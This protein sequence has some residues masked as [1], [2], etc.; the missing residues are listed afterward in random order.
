MSPDLHSKAQEI[1]AALKLVSEWIKPHEKDIQRLKLL[2]LVSEWVDKILRLDT[3]VKDLWNIMKSEQEGAGT[4]WTKQK[5]IDILQEFNQEEEIL[6]NALGIPEYTSHG[7]LG[8]YI[9]SLPKKRRLG[10]IAIM[11]PFFQRIKLI[12][13]AIK[14][15]ITNKILINNEWEWSINGLDQAYIL[16]ALEHFYEIISGNSSSTE[17]NIRI[18]NFTELARIEYNK[19]HWETNP[20]LAFA[21]LAYAL[22][23]HEE[24]S[25]KIKKWQHGSSTKL[26]ITLKED[27]DRCDIKFDKNTPIPGTVLEIN[28]WNNEH[29]VQN[30]ATALDNRYHKTV[31]KKA[32]LLIESVPMIS[33]WST[34]TFRRYPGIRAIEFKWEDIPIE[35]NLAMWLSNS[36]S[37]NLHLKKFISALLELKS[38][39]IHGTE[40]PAHILEILELRNK[41]I[42]SD[43]WEIENMYSLVILYVIENAQTFSKDLLL[44]IFEVCRK[45]GIR[46]FSPEIWNIIFSRVPQDPRIRTLHETLKTSYNPSPYNTEFPSKSGELLTIPSIF[47]LQDLSHFWLDSEVKKIFAHLEQNSSVV[48]ADLSGYSQGWKRGEYEWYS[49]RL[50]SAITLAMMHGDVPESLKNFSLVSLDIEK[51]KWFM[52]MLFAFLGW[53]EGRE[54]GAKMDA[55]QSIFMN[56]V[57]Y[58]PETIIIINIPAWKITGW[59]IG[60]MISYIESLWLKVIVESWENIPGIDRIV[61]TYPL[62]SLDVKSRLLNELPKIQEH[63]SI[64]LSAPVLEKGI[65]IVSRIRKAWSDPLDTILEVI[66]NAANRARAR[67]QES[68]TNSDFWSALSFVLQTIGSEGMKEKIDMISKLPIILK[69]VIVWQDQVIDEF[70][71]AVMGHITGAGNPD[72]PLAYLFP[73]PTGVGKTLLA[74][75]LNK[76]FNLPLLIIDGSTYTEKHSV[77]RLTSS[78][79]GYAG[80]DKDGVLTGFMKNNTTGI[81]FIDEFDKAH[82]AVRMELMNFVDKWTMTAWDG[83]VISRPQYIIISAT[84]AWA[85]KLRADMSEAEVIECIAEAF[86]DEEWIPKPELAARFRISPMLAIDERSFR[87]AIRNSLKEIESRQLFISKGISIISVS[88]AAVDYVFERVKDICQKQWGSKLMGFNQKNEGRYTGYYNLRQITHTVDKLIWSSITPI[89]QKDDFREWD[90]SIDLDRNNLVLKRIEKVD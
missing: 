18:V 17:E 63:L 74:D 45:F 1:L 59:N 68:I 46:E 3:S 84:N 51:E 26:W 27:I 12:R 61:Q 49:K 11:R 69:S 22:S 58:N 6:R 80:S 52:E 83:E 86:K 65:D 8:T 13:E 67:Q 14:T 90:Y 9:L 2:G 34:P 33:F 66:Q 30:I 32:F 53:W 78:P 79:P 24:N 89:V 48:Y 64:K 25:L 76:N 29:F 88:D 71:L 43:K 82:S 73:G 56:I 72:K 50:R 60:K 20:H 7:K 4:S 19:Y 28:E 77:A 23:G 62:T 57:R 87:T 41:S 55:I 5:I 37:N 40:R 47:Y 10:T 81:V 75:I 16:H 70:C 38:L 44:Q 54:S 35:I 31:S 15:P 85:E 36:W 21:A 39:R 42:L